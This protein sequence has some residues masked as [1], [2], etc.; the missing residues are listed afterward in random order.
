MQ[1]I[2]T[3]Q[4]H[5]T[6]NTTAASAG[7][8]SI[9]VGLNDSVHVTPPVAANTEQVSVA[10]RIAQ[11]IA[12]RAAWEQGAFY[13]SNTQLYALLSKCYALYDDLT[14]NEV[15]ARNARK[16]LDDAIRAKGLRVSDGTHVL[17]KLVKLVFDGFD[18]RRVSAYALV[19]R[20]AHAQG[21][22]A[23]EVAAF[24]TQGRGVEEI[25]RSKSKNF[26]SPAEKAALGKQAVGGTQ[27]AVVSGDKL[28]EAVKV[29]D[30]GNDL[31]A[32]VTQ[33]A[34]GSLVVRALVRSASVLKAALASAYSASKAA[35]Q[36]ETADRTAANDD[37]AQ[38]K[39]I[40][41]AAIS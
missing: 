17:N 10:E 22:R 1:D 39:R 20:E 25:R 27:L 28:A 40:S 3:V 29:G 31:I 11:L 38:T 18:R 16:A 6:V 7:V 2:A 21:K 14:G 24:I 13:K 30:T 23:D 34:D 32:I 35:V 19:L 15:R 26:K 5:T 12:E 9:P 4:Q 41:E 36:Q 8:P 33:Q 37:N